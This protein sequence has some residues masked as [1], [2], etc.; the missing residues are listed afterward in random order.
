[1]N[2]VAA[3]RT[4]GSPH[5]RAGLP[6]RAPTAQRTPAGNR[7][8]SFRAIGRV[9]RHPRR[10]VGA[11]ERGVLSHGRKKNASR[12]WATG[13]M[14]RVGRLRLRVESRKRRAEMII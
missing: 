10:D 2:T 3:D 13:K 7:I 14:G 1:M 5:N 11:I 6:G 9:T 12:V 4:G 8:N